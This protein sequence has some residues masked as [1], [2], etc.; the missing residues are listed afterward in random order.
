MCTTPGLNLKK[1]RKGKRTIRNVRNARKKTFNTK[2]VFYF[3]GGRGTRKKV[4][5]SWLQVQSTA[6]SN[7]FSIKKQILLEKYWNWKNSWR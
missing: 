6:T 5:L 2:V 7:S 4:F 1:N 3:Q